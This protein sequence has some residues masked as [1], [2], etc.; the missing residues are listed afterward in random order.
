MMMIMQF[1]FFFK[2]QKLPM[3]FLYSSFFLFPFFVQ[4]FIC[5]LLLLLIYSVVPSFI[6]VIYIILFPFSF[7]VILL[8]SFDTFWYY[9]TFIPFCHPCILSSLSFTFCH[10]DLS[11]ISSSSHTPGS[12]FLNHS[13]C[14]T[15]ITFFLSYRSVF[16]ACFLPF[17]GLYF[18]SK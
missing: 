18:N 12:F 17:I 14:Y 8:F 7:L 11:Y 10:F 1:L 4:L 3:S 2:D 16:L 5:S 6:P 9:S 13:C 15:F